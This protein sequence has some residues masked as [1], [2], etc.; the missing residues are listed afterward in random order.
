MRRGYIR[1]IEPLK[2]LTDT[3]VEAIHRGTLDVLEETG[4]QRSKI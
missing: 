4:F 2:I 1:N 3:Q